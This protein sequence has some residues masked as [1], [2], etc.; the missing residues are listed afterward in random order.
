MAAE[1]IDV[2]HD[3]MLTN[4]NDRYDKTEGKFMYDATRPIAIEMHLGQQ[5]N[6]MMMDKVNPRTSYGEWLTYIAASHGVNR[7]PGQKATC[8]NVVFYFVQDEVIPAGTMVST[9]SG[10]NYFTVSDVV[11]DEEGKAVVSIIAE[12]YGEDYNVPVDA[13][14]VISSNTDLLQGATVTNESPVTGGINPESDEELRERM[15]E[16][17]QNPPSSGNVADYVRWAKEVNG[18][19]GATVIP[20]WNGGG[21]VKIIVYGENGEPVSNEILTNV[22]QY[23]DPNDGTGEGKAPIG[24][25]VTVAT[26]TN[27]VIDV[28]ISGLVVKDGYTLEAVK[29]SINTRLADYI[30]NLP[31]RETLTDKYLEAIVTTTEGVKNYVDLKINGSNQDVTFTDEEKAIMGVV[32]YD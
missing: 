8:D 19:F 24:A 10:L 31:S 27:A 21:T 7:K 4:I 2:I 18:V 12:D 17:V 3:R 26:V 14:I 6:D 16:R 22:K 11:C 23:I 28:Q 13:V 15:F 5:E 20:T 32:T 1:E 30:N 9:T 25:T 29:N